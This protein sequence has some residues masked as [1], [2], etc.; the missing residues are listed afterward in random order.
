MIFLG[1]LVMIISFHSLKVTIFFDFLSA[2]FKKIA[3]QTYLPRFLTCKEK[4]CFA[5]KGRLF[6]EEACFPV[7]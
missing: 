3:G 2:F 1:R 7:S 6:M 4:L 5:K